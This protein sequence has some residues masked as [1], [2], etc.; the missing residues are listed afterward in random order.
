MKNYL[1]IGI[2]TVFSIGNALAQ[3]VNEKVEIESNGTWYPGKIVKINADGK[4]FFV[5]YDG[6][7]ETSNEWV[8]TE[9][10][11]FLVSEVKPANTGKFKIGDKVEV[12]YGMIPEPATIIEVGENKYH[13]KWDKSMY[14]DKWVS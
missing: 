4:E 2:L 1:I 13:I 12:E 5:S 3:K 7:E 11:K 8:T 6:W 9:R 14:G 10:L